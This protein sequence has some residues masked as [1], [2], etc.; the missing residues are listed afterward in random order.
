MALALLVLM[1]VT[2]ELLEDVKARFGAPARAE[3]IQIMNP[4]EY[5]L[6]HRS[7]AKNRTHD[8]TGFI[9]SSLGYACIAKH[10]Y[11]PG[12]WRPPSGGVDVGESVE[13][14]LKREM[15]EEVGL[16][17]SIDRYLLEVN[18][19]FVCEGKEG[20]SWFTH[21][22]LCSSGEEELAPIDTKE[23]KEARWVSRELLLGDIQN[24]MLASGWGG[25]EYRSR[26]ADRV[27]EEMDILKI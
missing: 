7:V 4:D 25:F 20:M 1:H 16:E 19:K 27:F 26:L 3:F 5:A 15:M 23:I 9:R 2:A 21:V 24:R 13:K 8:V 12:I 22:F 10:D 18:V 11:P 6:V 14:G 17:S